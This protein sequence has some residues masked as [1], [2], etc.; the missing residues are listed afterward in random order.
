M[1]NLIIRYSL[2]NHQRVHLN[3]NKIW[4]ESSILLKLNE[5][6]NESKIIMLE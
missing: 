3:Q 6:I 5:N 4:I 1:F 2:L